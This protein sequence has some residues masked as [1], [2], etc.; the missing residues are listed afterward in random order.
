MRFVTSLQ[1]IN[2]CMAVSRV[3]ADC[4]I[5]YADSLDTSLSKDKM[6]LY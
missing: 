5:I 2:L 3:V 1:N 6:M 4:G